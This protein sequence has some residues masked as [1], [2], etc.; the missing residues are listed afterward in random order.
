MHLAAPLAALAFSAP[1]SFS[2]P[3]ALS[4]CR[5]TCERSELLMVHAPARPAAASSFAAP[6]RR[7]LP[8]RWHTEW[9]APRGLGL[10]RLRCTRPGWPIGAAALHA[11]EAVVC[12]PDV[13]T[14]AEVE[15]LME[16]STSVA[17]TLRETGSAS[18]RMHVPQRFSG[19]EATLCDDIL[20]RVLL[21]VD[22]EFPR[23][24]A[25]R[26]GVVGEET[27]LSELVD[28][29]ELEFSPN[30]PAINIY[31]AGGGFTPHEDSCALTVLIPLSSSD[32]AFSGGGT[33]FWPPLSRRSHA[34][35]DEPSLVL[36]PTVGTALLFNGDVT[37][38]GLQ[39]V[40]GTRGVLVA[41]FSRKAAVLH[42]AEEQVEVEVEEAQ[43]GEERRVRKVFPGGTVQCYKGESGAERLVQAV[44]TDGTV[45]HFEGAS[46]AE[47]LAMAELPNGDVEYFE[48]EADAE[49]LVRKV[50]FSGEVQYI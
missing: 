28:L 49:R 27:A 32:D 3:C 4:Q 13:V 39:V 24:V 45:E 30:E 43:G 6:D 22:R 1:T 21:F 14:A 23:L 16:S 11:G 50:L 15:R 17:A 20:R 9:I 38:A 35:D 25:R 44:F 46:G 36:K 2:L 34:A 5:P 10:S 47:R 33:G 12:V 7:D 19:E 48:G 42:A 18:I 29:G 31:F 26:F 41:S 37:H 8:R 40:S